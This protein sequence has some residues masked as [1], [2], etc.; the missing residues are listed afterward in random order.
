MS[1]VDQR[2]A[3]VSCRKIPY[4]LQQQNR[5]SSWADS[6]IVFAVWHPSLSFISISHEAREGEVPLYN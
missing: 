2:V 4:I 1:V 3:V 5:L 6:I